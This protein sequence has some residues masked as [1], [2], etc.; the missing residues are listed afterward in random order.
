MSGHRFSSHFFL[1]LTF[2][3]H[4]YLSLASGEDLEGLDLF[5]LGIP[6]HRLAVQNTGRHRVFLHLLGE[7]NEEKQIR[8]ENKGLK[9]THKCQS[10]E[11]QYQQ[12]Q[13]QTL[14]GEV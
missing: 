8:E 7:N 3:S 10:T 13:Q 1:C 4:P 9:M 11:T 2:S 5:L 14:D 12:L 6:G